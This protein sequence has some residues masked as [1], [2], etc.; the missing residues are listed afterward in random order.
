MLYVGLYV[1]DFLLGLNNLRIF[2]TSIT[3]LLVFII[4]CKVDYLLL[5]LHLCISYCKDC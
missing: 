5:V 3:S 2:F 1:L 4:H